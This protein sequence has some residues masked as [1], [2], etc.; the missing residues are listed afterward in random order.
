MEVQKLEAEVSRL[1]AQLRELG[2]EN[3]RLQKAKQPVLGQIFPTVEERQDADRRSV[4]VRGF[5]PQTTAQELAQFFMAKVG[6]VE[7]A[8]MMMSRVTGTSLGYAYVQFCKEALA[9]QAVKMTDDERTFHVGIF[10][11]APLDVTLMVVPKRTNMPGM[12][13][14]YTQGPPPR[15]QRRIKNTENTRVG[16]TRDRVNKNDAHLADRIAKHLL[17]NQFFNLETLTRTS[18]RNN[19]FNSGYRERVSM[20]GMGLMQEN[21]SDDYSECHDEN[22]NSDIGSQDTSVKMEEEE[23]FFAFNEENNETRTANISSTSS[24]ETLSSRTVK[25][26][27]S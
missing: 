2:G 3:G 4:F 15:L 24:D 9:Q 20:K 13:K 19:T 1:K 26:K 6:T 16:K 11:G 14:H 8:T 21:D 22:D 12:R 25:H 7:R 18:L 10:G 5:P 27:A 23:D 17:Q